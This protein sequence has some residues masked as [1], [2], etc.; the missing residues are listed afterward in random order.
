MLRFFCVFTVQETSFSSRTRLVA[1][2]AGKLGNYRQ[3][4]GAFLNSENSVCSI[5]ESV[6]NTLFSQDDDFDAV[7]R[8][9]RSQPEG[10]SGR[11]KTKMSEIKAF[12]AILNCWVKQDLSGVWYLVHAKWFASQA[13]CQL[14]LSLW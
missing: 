2:E 4:A 11:K 6:G 1:F 7:K 8:G 12:V 14:H 9:N 3:P 10:E 5:N 13:V